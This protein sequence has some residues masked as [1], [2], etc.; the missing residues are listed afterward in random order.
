MENG[1]HMRKIIRLELLIVACVLCAVLSPA[2]ELQQREWVVDGVIRE[3]L[4]WIPETEA[5]A[6][7]VFAFH[8][9]GGN[10]RGVA[11]QF[12]YH[13]IWT[14]AVVVYM[15]GLPTPIKKLDP[16]GKRSGWQIDSGDQDDRDLK[17]FDEVYAS[18]L[19]QIDPDR[20]Y[21]TGHSNGGRFAY[22]LWA[23]RG[24]LFAAIAPSGCP[25]ETSLRDAEPK[26]VLHIAGKKDR[27]Y[28][29]QKDAMREARR[30]NQCE[31]KGEPWHS[32]DGLVGTLYQSNRGAPF[33]SLISPGG[34]KLP[35]AAPELIVRFFK[36]HIRE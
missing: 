34:H 18:L 12:A 26:P 16:E 9:H 4:V 25:L 33:V 24:D 22:L 8:G 6:P 1:S 15:Q 10:M 36:E 27:Q 31:S 23:A 3:A 5:T 19:E 30:V 29:L 32:A 2:G 28:T 20:V 7:T 17:F 14:E 35:P 21:C 11:R 13:K